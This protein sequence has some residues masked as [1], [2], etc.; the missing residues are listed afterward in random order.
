[1]RFNVGDDFAIEECFL[2]F[3]SVT[4]WLG[5]KLASTVLKNL[6]QIGTD[7]LKMRGQGYSGAATMSGKTNDAQAYIREV[8]LTVPNVLC[9]TRNRNLVVSNLC[10]LSDL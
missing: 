2:Q 10:D 1:M 9:S 5:K 8:I 4:Y 3:V 7:V 6:F